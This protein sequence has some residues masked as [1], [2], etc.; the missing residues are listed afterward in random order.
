VRSL[1]ESETFFGQFVKVA[2]VPKNVFK[3]RAAAECLWHRNK[4]RARHWLRLASRSLTLHDG[5]IRVSRWKG[6][7]RAD[8]KV[9][10]IYVFRVLYGEE[11]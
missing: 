5:G 8:V 1:Y 3:L 6:R 10:C 9:D 2:E 11:C 4:M 7:A